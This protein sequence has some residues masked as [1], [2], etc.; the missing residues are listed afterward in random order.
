MVA[1]HLSVQ[2]TDGEPIGL[3][4]PDQGVFEGGS[5]RAP[6]RLSAASRSSASEDEGDPALDGKARTTTFVPSG[7]KA[8][9]SRMRCRNCRLTRLRSTAEPT[10]LLTT[11]PTDVGPSAF[12]TTCV[13]RVGCTPLAPRRIVRRNSSLLRMRSL[14]ASMSLRQT[15]WRGPCGGGPRGSRGRRG[16]A[17]GGGSRASWSDDDYWAGKYAY[18][19]LFLTDF[20]LGRSTATARPR[21]KSKVS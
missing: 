19:R 17:C 21:P 18:S 15:A 20:S 4:K 3:E 9:L 7:N 14:R 16:C 6:H 11:K 1:A 10:D 13:T 2:R 5:H 12:G 8:T